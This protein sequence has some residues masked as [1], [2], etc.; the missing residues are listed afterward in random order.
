[1]I[2]IQ[3]NTGYFILSKEQSG[4]LR[5]G[6]PILK[7]SPNAYLTHLSYNGKN[8]FKT[9]NNIEIMYALDLQIDQTP[10]LNSGEEK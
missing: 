5:V 4:K 8:V 7:L 6:E 9:W 1:M 2:Q 3:Q 10:K